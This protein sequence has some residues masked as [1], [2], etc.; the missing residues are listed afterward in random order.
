[1]VYRQLTNTCVID[2]KVSLHNGHSPQFGHPYFSNNH[3]A[4][5]ILFCIA[6][7]GVGACNLPLK[8]APIFK[9]IILIPIGLVGLAVPSLIHVAL[10]GTSGL[11][12]A[13]RNLLEYSYT[14]LKNSPTF[15]EP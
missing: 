13:L 3:S 9:G 7:Q 2:S 1:M 11:L 6:S 15:S 8:F 12:V 10:L 4:V 5:Q 14:I